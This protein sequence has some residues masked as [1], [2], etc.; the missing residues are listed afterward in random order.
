MCP[1][2]CIVCTFAC[3]CALGYASCA[4]FL[5]HVP[6]GM[7]R[8]HF[9][10]HMCPGVCIVP[11]RRHGGPHDR[12]HLDFPLRHFTIGPE[13]VH[14][15]HRHASDGTVSL[16]RHASDGTVS[17]HRH[18]SD[19]TESLHKHASDGTGSLHKHASDG[20]GSWLRHAI[21]RAAFLREVAVQE[22]CTV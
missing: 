8:V 10:L 4:L 11:W 3:T 16:H 18:A 14:S 21:Q 1:G 12:S 20:T 13:Q 6:W 15:W 5:A 9:C 19:G 7:H 2:V 22:A 17:L